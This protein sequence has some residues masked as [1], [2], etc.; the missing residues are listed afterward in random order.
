M[1]DYAK[2]VLDRA[3]MAARAPTQVKAEAAPPPPPAPAP[4]P[5]VPTGPA[6]RRAEAAEAA[7][8]R[9]TETL[10]G[11][12]QALTDPAVFAKDPAKAA[13]LGRRRDAAQQAVDTA[14][15]EWLEAQEAYEALR[16][17]A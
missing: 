3:R 1:E 8:A 10:A 7:L 15:Q 17:D 2:F 6:R 14:E 4:K 5:K 11:I 16:A 13:D 9:A 12:D